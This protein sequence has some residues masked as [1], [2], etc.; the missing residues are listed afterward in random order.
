VNVEVNRLYASNK[1]ESRLFK[2]DSAFEKKDSGVFTELAVF[3]ERLKKS[4][5]G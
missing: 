2:V 3:C 5:P 1:I 4:K